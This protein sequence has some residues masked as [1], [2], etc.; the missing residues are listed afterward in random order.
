MH[1]HE[2]TS[3]SPG[4]DREPLRAIG[5]SLSVYYRDRARTARMDRLHARFITPGALAFDIGAHVGDRTASFLRLG[6]SVVALEPQPRL[7]RALRLIHGRN[8]CATLR[9]HAVGQ[10]RGAAT[11]H[12][13]PRNPTVATLAPAFIAAAR[14]VPGWEGQVWEG[15]IE[16]PVT[17]LDTLIAEF[18]EPDFVKID[19]EGHE[20]AVLQGLSC[21]L[22]LLSFEITTLQR[23]VALACIRYLQGLGRHEFNL[24]LGEEHRLRHRPWLCAQ[25]MLEVVST[26]PDSANSGDI[27]ARRI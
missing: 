16:V 9:P 13:N 18:G 1:G 4:Q 5:R 23:S 11:L 22:P 3:H 26:L 27:Y 10:R 21:A 24:S 20:L 25:E 2:D 15:Q 8:A 7:F 14:N 12:L 6:A 17:T 19:V